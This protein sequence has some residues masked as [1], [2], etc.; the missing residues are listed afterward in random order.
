MRPVD[1]VGFLGKLRP[2]G[3]E[4][5]DAQASSGVE[6]HGH[7]TGMLHSLLA[8]MSGEHRRRGFFSPAFRRHGGGLHGKD[9]SGHH[10]ARFV[11]STRRVITGSLVHAYLV[12][13][14]CRDP[15]ARRT[16]CRGRSRRRIYTGRPRATASATE[17][18]S[19]RL[20]PISCRRANGY[21]PPAYRRR[22]ATAMRHPRRP[23]AYGPPPASR[24]RRRRR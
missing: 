17:H 12:A 23:P 5:A 20:P 6:N 22:R 2:H 21:A 16:F 14:R 4:P 7:S 1:V 18:M 24:R 8:G 9:L 3:E 10:V 19:R 11:G 15:V 13:C